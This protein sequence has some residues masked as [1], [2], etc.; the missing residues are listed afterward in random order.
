MRIVRSVAKGGVRARQRRRRAVAGTLPGVSTSRTWDAAPA[1]PR[2]DVAVAGANQ[3][4]VGDD[5]RH[6]NDF[7]AQ[8]PV[9]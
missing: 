2:L 9:S 1:G 4:L 3:P 5:A 7:L 8:S 6:A